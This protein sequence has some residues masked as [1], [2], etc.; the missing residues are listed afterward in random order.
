MH[1]SRQLIE[2]RRRDKRGATRFRGPSP[3]DRG[4]MLQV[5]RCPGCSC[6]RNLLFWR[7]Y[8][9]KRMMLSGRLLRAETSRTE[10]NW[11][12]F[13]IRQ[14]VD[15]I[16]ERWHSYF[17]RVSERLCALVGRHTCQSPNL[18]AHCGRIPSR[19]FTGSWHSTS[20]YSVLLLACLLV[21]SE[22]FICLLLNASGTSSRPRGL[23]RLPTYLAGR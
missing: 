2:T 18:A 3:V 7:N 4:H 23:Q 20:Q 21:R 10:L 8:V 19:N 5:A 11:K 14:R 6:R 1:E 17:R 15:G 13:G 16:T 22:C 9:L 12:R